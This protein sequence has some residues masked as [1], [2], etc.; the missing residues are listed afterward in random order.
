MNPT[1]DKLGDKI[2]ITIPFTRISEAPPNEM[3]L[4]T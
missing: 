2:K 1:T 3:F 4:Q